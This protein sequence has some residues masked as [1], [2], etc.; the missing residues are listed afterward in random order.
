MKINKELEENLGQYTKNSPIYVKKGG[1][2]NNYNIDI[3]RDSKGLVIGDNAKIVIDS[4][5]EVY[6][7]LKSTN[8]Y[9]DSTKEQ[10]QNKIKELGEAINKKDK[11][12]ISKIGEFIKQNWYNVYNIMK[13]AIKFALGL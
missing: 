2:V 12:L 5:N 11:S 6:E 9:D 3:G 7:F 8:E 1:V 13:P 4:F 10:I